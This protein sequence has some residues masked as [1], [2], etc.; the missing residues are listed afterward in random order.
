MTATIRG[1]SADRRDGGMDAEYSREYT[2]TYFVTTDD[3]DDG[4][5]IVMNCPGI[6]KLGGL[7]VLGNDWDPQ[8]TV[9]SIRAMQ[10]DAPNEWEVE[11]VYQTDRKLAPDPADVDLKITASTRSRMIVIPGFY[12]DP[13]NAVP[14]V[15]YDQGVHNSA[16]MHFDPPPEIEWEEPVLTINRN[17]RS[18][19]WP[20][21]MSV[22]NSVNSDDF[23]GCPPRTL[24][25]S[26]P[27][28]ESAFDADTGEYWKMTYSLI[29]KYDTW[30][31]QILNRGEYYLQETVSPSD[32]DE[33]ETFKDKEGRPFSGLLKIDGK[34]LNES[35]TKWIGRVRPDGTGDEPTFQRFRVY[36]EV[37]FNTI[38]IL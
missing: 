1:I 24:K 8:A 3:N 4:A 31:V 16:G 30:D 2:I 20:F 12:E 26:T 34:P 36:R 15:G 13:R 22:T 17:V 6:P 33:P 18:V 10:R 23:F 38:G 27:T 11:V 28:V 7:Y 9:G 35:D 5:Q 19:D 32:N 37:D 21:I 29:Y 25:L 14:D